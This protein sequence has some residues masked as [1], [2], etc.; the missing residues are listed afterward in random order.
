LE[1]FNQDFVE[2]IANDFGYGLLH[3]DRKEEA[4]EVFKYN[5]IAY[6]KSANAYD[7]LGEAYMIH[8][9]RKLAIQNYRKSLKLDPNNKNARE[10]LKKLME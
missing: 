3:A 10:L 2:S 4:V 8:G 6:P 7:S 9:D 1:V 5:T